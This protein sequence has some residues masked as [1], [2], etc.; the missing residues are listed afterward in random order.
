M[1]KEINVKRKV[2]KKP[3]K[4]D[5]RDKRIKK[6]EQCVGDKDRRI[7]KLEKTIKSFRNSMCGIGSLIFIAVIIVGS[8]LLSTNNP[9]LF[10]EILKT[11]GVIGIT[12]ITS[13][14][15]CTVII[16]VDDEKLK[17]E[18]LDAMAVSC[19]PTGIV[20]FIYIFVTILPL[21]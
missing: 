15:V 7:T 12:F 14:V 1:K 4:I 16:Y 13:M 17:E 21:L 19:L 3:L 2:N 6:L 9:Y 8:F 10:G 5:E 11:C 18:L 20:T